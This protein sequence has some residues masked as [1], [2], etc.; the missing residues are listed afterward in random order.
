MIT[1]VTVYIPVLKTQEKLALEMCIFL[2]RSPPNNEFQK[3]LEWHHELPK[4]TCLNSPTRFMGRNRNQE[5]INYR[6]IN[7]TINPVKGQV[8]GP[9]DRVTSEPTSSEAL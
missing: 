1:L 3:H 9:W 8:C 6:S 4:Q 2:T 7:R 5:V